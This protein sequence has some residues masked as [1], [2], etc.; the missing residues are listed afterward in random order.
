[1]LDV[2]WAH[3]VAGHHWLAFWSNFLRPLP[4]DWRHVDG[5]LRGICWVIVQRR[6]VCWEFRVTEQCIVVCTDL[7]DLLDLVLDR[8]L[9][10]LFL[11][12][13]LIMLLVAHHFLSILLAHLVSIVTLI[14]LKQLVDLLLG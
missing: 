2:A 5:V 6:I 10:G 9:L 13:H 14:L 3:F 1:M 12:M 11:L 4:L 7:D 8:V